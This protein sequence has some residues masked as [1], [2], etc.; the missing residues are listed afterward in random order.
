MR[1]EARDTGKAWN[2]GTV[3]CVKNGVRVKLDSELS[4]C[5]WDEVRP[6]THEPEKPKTGV[7]LIKQKIMEDAQAM[8]NAA[9]EEA[10]AELK[11]AVEVFRDASSQEVPD[12]EALKDAKVKVA[13]AIKEAQAKG[14]SP[15]ELI[16]ASSQMGVSKQATEERVKPE[17]TE[18]E[19][20]VKKEKV[21]KEKVVIEFDNPAVGEAARAAAEKAK[22]EGLSLPEMIKA[23]I[24]ALQ[25]IGGAGPDD[26]KKVKKLAAEVALDQSSSSSSDDSSDTEMEK[27]IDKDE[28]AKA[29]REGIAAAFYFNAG[30]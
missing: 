30:K 9:K 5:G 6:L 10:L 23:A 19:E 18:K 15:E 17:E 12:P 29:K 16:E 25:A 27:E 7:D 22:E 28:K 20:R 26:I 11:K 8:V 14:V 4:G 24:T 21:K 13:A 2:P 1:V 3:T